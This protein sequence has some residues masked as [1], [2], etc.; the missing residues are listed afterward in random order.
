MSERKNAE[1]IELLFN[2]FEVPSQVLKLVFDA[3]PDGFSGWVFVL[4][5][6]QVAFSGYFSVSPGLL[7]LRALD[8][9]FIN[10]CFCDLPGF[11]Q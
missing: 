2:R 8:M 7:P 10:D 3:L 9:Q 4:G 11:I 6:L 1:A 5:Y